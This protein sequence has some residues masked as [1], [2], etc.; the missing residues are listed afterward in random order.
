MSIK[1]QLLALALLTVFLWP[2]TA[3]QPIQ[4]LPAVT[5]VATLA[6]PELPATTDL[7]TADLANEILWDKWGVPHIF[8]QD[9]ASSFYALGWAQTHGRGDLL[10]RL[11]A[12]AH[13]RAA[14]F[15]GE[16]YRQ[17]DQMTRLLG[18]PTL[19]E[20]W[21]QQQPNGL[22]AQSGRLCPWD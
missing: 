16:E 1:K 8:A 6:E 3:C 18:I 12:T 19:G 15:Y 13:G 11:Y 9:S 7:A 14:E 2:L 22:S 10:L 17:S 5:P 20:A 4:P 21:Y